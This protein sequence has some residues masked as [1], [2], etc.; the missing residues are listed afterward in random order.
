MK[1]ERF[2][3]LLLKW[4]ALWYIGQVLDKAFIL[5]IAI[6]L[7]GILL[8]FKLGFEKKKDSKE[9]YRKV[10]AENGKKI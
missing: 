6:D 7:T 9:F 5:Y 1:W 3:R 2:G 10:E 8:A 4:L